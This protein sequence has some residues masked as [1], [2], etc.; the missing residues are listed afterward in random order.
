MNI[1]KLDN[2]FFVVCEHEIAR[3][4]HLF[5]RV[6]SVLTLL[7]LALICILAFVGCVC[8]AAR[9]K[10]RE[11]IRKKR[12]EK[13]IITK[14]SLKSHNNVGGGRILYYYRQ[15]SREALTS[16]TKEGLLD[17]INSFYPLLSLPNP[18]PPH[19]PSSSLPCS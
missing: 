13:M 3:L 12:K 2:I 18:F 17:I 15:G 1:S 10:I 5:V 7:A 11:K 8:I 9:C 4:F 16:T 6:F 14:H 19:L